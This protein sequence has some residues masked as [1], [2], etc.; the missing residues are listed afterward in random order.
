MVLISGQTRHFGKCLYVADL[1]SVCISTL[2]GYREICHRENCC[3]L[4][5][6]N[7]FFLLFCAVGNY[8]FASLH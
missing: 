7:D 3:S 4:F 2:H 6:V 8:I 1:C 5:S